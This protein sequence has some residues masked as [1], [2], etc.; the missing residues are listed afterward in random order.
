LEPASGSH[1]AITIIAEHALPWA[2]L[3]VLPPRRLKRSID[4]GLFAQEKFVQARE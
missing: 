2:R 1:K 3:P 4:S